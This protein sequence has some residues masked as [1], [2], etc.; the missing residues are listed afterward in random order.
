MNYIAVYVQVRG[1]VRQCLVATPILSLPDAL[2][3]EIIHWVFRNEDRYIILL[4]YCLFVVC[5]VLVLLLLINVQM[6]VVDICV[7]DDVCVG[8]ESGDT[9]EEE[10]VTKL[11]VSS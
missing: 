3:E 11:S 10:V 1:V 6:F 4:F 2:Q 8:V 7:I 5:V 9:V